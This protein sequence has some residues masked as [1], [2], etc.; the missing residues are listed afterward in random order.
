MKQKDTQNW[1]AK[2]H[3]FR[4]L[5]INKSWRSK[6]TDKNQTGTNPE[7]TNNINTELIAN[8]SKSIGSSSRNLSYSE[9]QL[10]KMMEILG[11]VE[12]ALLQ[13]QGK[14]RSAGKARVSGRNM[15]LSTFEKAQLRSE[16]HNL[17]NSQRELKEDI[18]QLANKVK[19]VY[20]KSIQ[21]DKKR[22][23]RITARRETYHKKHGASIEKAITKMVTAMAKDD[24]TILKAGLAKAKGDTLLMRALLNAPHNLFTRVVASADA[25]N[26]YLQ[27]FRKELSATRSISPN[28]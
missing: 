19:S 18:K 24:I 26:G 25:R 5:F 4:K 15:K 3:L 22:S 9:D 20:R 2:Y 8:L 7:S 21:R 11:A 14:L 28:K 6:M 17:K 12:A 1:P 10:S 16:I 23:L 13:K 27:H